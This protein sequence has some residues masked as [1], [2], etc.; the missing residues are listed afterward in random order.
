MND[1]QPDPRRLVQR[2]KLDLPLIGLYDAP[3]PEPFAPLEA[4][5][6]GEC[7]FSFYG[8]WLSGRT[9]HLT[10]DHYGCGGCG[11]WMF[12]ISTRSREDFIK[13]LV[14]GE[15]LKASRE[16]MEEWIDASRPYQRSHPHILIGPLNPGQ[17]RWC[18]S[19][20]FFVDPDRLSALVYGTQYSAAPADPAPLIAP[21]GSGCMQLIPFR[22]LSIPQAALGATDIAMRRYLPPDILTVSVTRSMFR[23]LCSLD[24]NSFL[25]KPFLQALQKARQ[26]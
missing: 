19:V 12:D 21:F 23:R 22:D 15:G 13:F 8:L 17:W 10:K 9:L 26:P 2:L 25:Y 4:P 1:R 20:I 6:A 5:R 16:L 7:L 14:D 11:R 3:D 18:R 24:E